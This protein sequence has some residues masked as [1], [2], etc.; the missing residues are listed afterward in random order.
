AVPPFGKRM[1]AA[2]A[3]RS[4]PPPEPHL[5][6]TGTP[7]ASPGSV[8]ACRPGSATRGLVVPGCPSGELPEG[9]AFLVAQGGDGLDILVVR[10][11]QQSVD[12]GAGAAALL[13]GPSAGRAGPLK[14]GHEC[15]SIM[16]GERAA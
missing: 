2:G 5:P 13:G 15:V 10:V 3:G 14:R 16:V 4:P 12:A 9:L 8:P 6:R 7:P 11:G 1:V